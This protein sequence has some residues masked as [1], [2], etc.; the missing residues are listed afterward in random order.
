MHG[1]VGVLHKTL[2]LVT[3]RYKFVTSRHGDHTSACLKEPSNIHID[4]VFTMIRIE[5]N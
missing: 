5:K 4:W 2:S 3:L 1:T